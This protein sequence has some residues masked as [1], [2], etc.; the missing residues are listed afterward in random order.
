MKNFMLFYTAIK[1]RVIILDEQLANTSKCCYQV[2]AVTFVVVLLLILECTA[3]VAESVASPLFS[4]GLWFESRMK[5]SF[6]LSL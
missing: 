2:F 3:K 1:H 6:L 5:E 4:K